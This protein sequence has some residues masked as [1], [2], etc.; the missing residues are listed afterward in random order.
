[1]IQLNKQTP[2]T[3]DWE[4]EFGPIG[5]DRMLNAI[6]CSI[7]FVEASDIF[8]IQDNFF[9]VLDSTWP[10]IFPDINW[11]FCWYQGR[12]IWSFQQQ[13]P[14]EE[15][16]WVHNVSWK[17][18]SRNIA[19][20]YKWIFVMSGRIRS[21]I[22]IQPNRFPTNLLPSKLYMTLSLNWH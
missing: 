16:W 22:Y 8:L 7:T 10:N 5:R 20:I 18:E 1:M 3:G 11:R 4:A 17:R 13:Q 12:L 2:N 21:S 14:M 9:S 19:S 15:F 6:H